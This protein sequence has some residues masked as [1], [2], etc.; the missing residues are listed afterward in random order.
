MKAER[1]AN[2]GQPLW[3]IWLADL[4]P[5]KH[6]DPAEGWETLNNNRDVERAYQASERDPRHSFFRY[7]QGGKNYYIEFDKMVSDD[8]TRYPEINRVQCLMANRCFK[9]GDKVSYRSIRRRVVPDPQA[10]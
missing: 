2:G 1:A 4:K 5:D 9:N 7:K 6:E 8:G 10:Q 3:E